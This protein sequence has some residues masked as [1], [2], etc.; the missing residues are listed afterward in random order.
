MTAQPTSLSLASSGGAPPGIACA[1]PDSCAP[2][3]CG[4]RPTGVDCAPPPDSP[5]GGRPVMIEA[6]LP[7][8]PW[9]RQEQTARYRREASRMT[10]R[11]QSAVLLLA[12]DAIIV[13]LPNGRSS[14]T[15]QA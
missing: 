4:P 10:R 13:I 5:G 15:N 7:H 2:A 1:R 3:P 12:P 9:E 14:R 11:V 8:L 6:A